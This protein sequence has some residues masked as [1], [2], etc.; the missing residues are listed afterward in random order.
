MAESPQFWKENIKK[1]VFYKKRWSSGIQ[2]LA[3]RSEVVI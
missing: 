2:K 1:R 3:G